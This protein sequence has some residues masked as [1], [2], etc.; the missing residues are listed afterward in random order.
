MQ[1]WKMEDRFKFRVWDVDKARYNT[2]ND[3]VLTPDGILGEW[4][5]IGTYEEDKYIVEQCTGFSDK[6]GNLIYEGDIVKDSCGRKG[7]VS[8]GK[9]TGCFAVGWE[10]TYIDLFGWYLDDYYEPDDC[11][12][13]RTNFDDTHSPITEEDDGDFEIIG[14]I[15]EQ[16]EQKG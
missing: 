8:F 10:N 13:I 5:S 11:G 16:A 12:R 6:N 4:D 7:V 1:D 2:D 9:Y 14:N 15:H 3:F